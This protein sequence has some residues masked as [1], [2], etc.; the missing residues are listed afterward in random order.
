MEKRALLAFVL[1]IFVIVGYYH[2]IAKLYPPAQ[3]P[4]QRPEIFE[5]KVIPAE[6]HS[7]L[8]TQLLAKQEVMTYNTKRYE[9]LIGNIGGAIKGINLKDYSGRDGARPMKLAELINSPGIFSLVSVDG[10]DLSGA[11]YRITKED[12]TVSCQYL[13]PDKFEIVKR[14]HFFPD[15]YHIE[16]EIIFRNLAP[17]TQEHRYRIVGG[18]G[19]DIGMGGRWNKRFI[20]AVGIVNGELKRNALRRASRGELV[21]EGEILW[22]GL[23]SK[24][25][26]IILKPF[27]PTKASFCNLVEQDKLQTGIE[28][29]PFLVSPGSSVTHKF[30]LYAGPND[31]DILKSYNFRF[32]EIISFGAFGG[33]SK[34][35]LTTLKF[36]YRLVGNW[37]VS[38]MLL[39]LT[40]SLLL[41]PL[42]YKSM[43]SM[44]GMQIIQP[45]INKLREAHKDNP[46]KLNREIMELY[47]KH[48]I[49]PLGGCLP[50]LFQMPIFIALYQTLI[51]S[52]ELKGAH[53]FWIKDLSQPDALSIPFSL[54][55][56]GNSVNVLPVLMSV[57]MFIQ[58]KVS[59]PGGH[60][61]TEQQK[62]MAVFMPVLFGIIFYNLP[63]GL[64]LYW[65]T[66]TSLMIAYQGVI[67]KG[68]L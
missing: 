42:T 36:F 49:N 16:L 8:P 68:H 18:A 13:I 37:G 7:L 27:I 25:F 6:K 45:E 12:D 64:V 41:Y 67:K 55:L 3:A 29:A 21:R 51:R 15:K 31:Y 35:L 11:V 43:K 53:F 1:A 40:V 47:R 23:K 48:K 22:T 34:L 62:Q 5:E 33:I 2:L 24:Y 20:E 26:S 66:N 28:V 10:K 39:T 30:L 52:I 44:R 4:E 50:L 60:A 61:Q 63:S 56:L 59:Q 17:Q 58:Q 57:A 19:I 65:L 54:P 14:Y 38:I 46:Q 32:E 9:I